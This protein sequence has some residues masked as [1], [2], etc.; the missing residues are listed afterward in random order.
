MLDSLTR[1][2]MPLSMSLPVI[3]KVDGMNLFEY[4]STRLLLL[5]S[6]LTP[7]FYRIY[8]LRKY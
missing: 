1:N 7:I 8:S 4:L 5:S 2:L 6:L 3:G